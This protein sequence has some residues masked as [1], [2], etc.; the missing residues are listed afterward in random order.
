MVHPTISLSF[1]TNI[2]DKELIS[3]TIKDFFFPG[4]DGLPFLPPPAQMACAGN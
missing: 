1:Q 3:Q 4:L 2:N